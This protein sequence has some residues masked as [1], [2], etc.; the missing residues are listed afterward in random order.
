MNNSLAFPGIFRGAIDTKAKA[1]NLEMKIAAAH[2]IAECIPEKDL[3]PESI[4]PGAL[5]SEIPAR[6]AKAVA[7]AAMETGVA[8]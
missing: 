1:I 3:T 4:L 8:T 6:V 2:A 5:N 7:K